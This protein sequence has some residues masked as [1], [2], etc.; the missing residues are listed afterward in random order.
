MRK[1]L[2]VLGLCLVSGSALAQDAGPVDTTPVAVSTVADPAPV[3]DP[4][5]VVDPA[6]VAVTADAAPVATATVPV[7]T[8]PTTDSEALGMAANLVTA[9]KSGSW[10]VFCGF[11]LMVL[12]Y[13]FRRF[14]LDKKIPA[15]ALPWVTLGVGCVMTFS[16]ALANGSTWLHAL[17]SGFLVS[18]SATLLWNT[19][20]QHIAGLGKKPTVDA[21]VTQTPPPA[22]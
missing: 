21:T 12:I 2:V 14:G 20:G 1:F 4:V 11:L 17:A 22:K 15:K 8:E 5:V 13:G 16:V 10:V 3:V 7:V 9:A 19:V 18:A 6:P